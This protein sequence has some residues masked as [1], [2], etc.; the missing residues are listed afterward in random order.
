LEA[1]LA[2]KLEAEKPRLVLEAARRI[3]WAFDWDITKEHLDKYYE[4]WKKS[5]P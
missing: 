5:K 4:K 1:I 2:G 3:A